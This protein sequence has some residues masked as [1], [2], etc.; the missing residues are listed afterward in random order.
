MSVLMSVLRDPRNEERLERVSLE[1]VW[2]ETW[3]ESVEL[4]VEVDEAGVEVVRA[5]VEL[6]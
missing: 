6:V 2:P 1:L 4:G 3:T 5:S